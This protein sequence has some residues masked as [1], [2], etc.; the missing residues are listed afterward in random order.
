MPAIEICDLCYR[1]PSSNGDWALT[2]ITLD[3]EPGEYVLLCGASGSG[4]STLARA[5]NG[6]IPHFYEGELRGHVRVG[7]LDT[8]EH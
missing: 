1:Y 7:G 3:V 6:L 2:E 4:K 8:R 5:L